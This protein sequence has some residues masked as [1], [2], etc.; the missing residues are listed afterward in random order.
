MSSANASIVLGSRKRRRAT[1]RPRASYGQAIEIG[2]R[3]RSNGRL[4]RVGDGRV[5]MRLN[6]VADGFALLDEVMVSVSRGEW[7]R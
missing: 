7:R 2:A 4:A 5:L 6:Q 1:W 3:S